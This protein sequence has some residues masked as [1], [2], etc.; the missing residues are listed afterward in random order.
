MVRKKFQETYS[1]KFYQHSIN[2]TLTTL[3]YTTPFNHQHKRGYVRNDQLN[4]II[5]KRLFKHIHF[6]TLITLNKMEELDMPYIF[7]S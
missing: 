4:S 3:H 6:E 2:H 1:V 7:T 5:V